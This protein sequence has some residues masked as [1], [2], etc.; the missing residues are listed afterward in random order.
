MEIVDQRIKFAITTNSNKIEN[1]D[2]L[3][4]DFYREDSVKGGFGLGLKIVKDI[5]DKNN[6][7]MEVSS[8]SKETKFIYRFDHENII[9]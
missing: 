5:C 8:S 9:A 4:Q 3:C 1:I 6:V 2:L 7:I